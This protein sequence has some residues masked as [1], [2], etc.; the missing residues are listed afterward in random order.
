MAYLCCPQW[1]FCREG[2][3]DGIINAAPL[4]SAGR[5]DRVCRKGSGRGWQICSQGIWV[6][7]GSAGRGGEGAE[8]EEGVGRGRDA[9]IR[10]VPN[11]GFNQ[12]TIQFIEKPNE[13]P[14][15][16]ILFL[17]MVIIRDVP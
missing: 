4:G 12:K 7:G 13:P 14:K 6:G 15:T 16:M 3:L 5:M 1:I 2:T 10:Q 9:Q 8:G 17:F 11:V